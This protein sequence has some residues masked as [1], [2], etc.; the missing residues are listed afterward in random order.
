MRLSDPFSFTHSPIHLSRLASSSSS[1]KLQRQWRGPSRE[2]HTGLHFSRGPLTLPLSMQTDPDITAGDHLYPSHRMTPLQIPPCPP[3]PTSPN[4]AEHRTI[5]Y[6]PCESG[7]ASERTTA[8]PHHAQHLPPHL[9]N[10]ADSRLR[11]APS[12]VHTSRRTHL[13]M[14]SIHPLMLPVPPIQTHQGDTVGTTPVQKTR[15]AP[16]T[17]ASAFIGTSVIEEVACLSRKH[18]AHISRQTMPG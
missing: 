10:T 8:L 17:Q 6:P 16:T 5:A 11:P 7:D 18:S 12:D 2:T 15:V 13:Q 4:M 3:T 9:D 14:H 1:S